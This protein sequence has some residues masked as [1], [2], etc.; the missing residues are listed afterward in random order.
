MNEDLE[1][2]YSKYNYKKRLSLIIWIFIFG[3]AIIGIIIVII[4]MQLMSKSSLEISR[5]QGMKFVDKEGKTL[6][7]HKY[8]DYA[9]DD[10]GRIVSIDTI[11]EYHSKWFTNLLIALVVTAI[12]ITAI[13]FCANY[14][15]KIIKE[16]T[17]IEF[18]IERIKYKH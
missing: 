17:H 6:Y 15:K 13:I 12:V 5:R 16:I 11:P 14:N 9:I 4:Q 2:L 1:S 8:Q 7:E 10:E 3:I 18:E